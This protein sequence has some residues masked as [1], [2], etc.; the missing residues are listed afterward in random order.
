MRARGRLPVALD[1][2]GGTNAPGE[3]VL[4][5]VQAARETG[6]GDYPRWP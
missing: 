1:A 2:M 6:L 5:A 3:V 4:G